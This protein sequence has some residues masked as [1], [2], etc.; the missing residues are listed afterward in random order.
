MSRSS[1]PADAQHGLLTQRIP[2]HSLEAERAVLGSLLLDGERTA[3]VAGGLTPSAFYKDGHRR[4]FAAMLHLVAV[5]SPVDLLTV[6]EVLKQRSELDD[7]GGPA[8]LAGLVEEAAIA[9]H[10]PAQICAIVREKSTKRELIRLGT[11]LVL[12]GYEE[13]EARV[14]LDAAR[15]SLRA[16]EAGPSSSTVLGVGLGAFLGQ[17]FSAPGRP[18]SRG[19]SCR[20]APGGLPARRSSARASMPYSRAS[21]S[22]RWACPCSA[23]TAS[24]ISDGCSSS[25]RKIRRDVSGPASG[26]SCADWTLTPTTLARGPSWTRF[27]VVVWEGVTLD[28]PQHLARLSATLDAF[29]AHVVYLDVLRKLTGKDLNKAQE[30]GALLGALDELRRRHG[31]V[32]RVLHHY[33]KSQG[34]RTGRGSQEIGGSFAL[35]AWGECSL[36]F[37]P[38]GR[39]QGAVRVEVQTKDGAPVPAFR[40]T[41]HAEGPADAPDLL[42][43]MAEDVTDD[44]SV[45][46]QLAQAVATLEKSEAVVGKPGVAVTALAA[47]LKKSDKSIRRGLKRLEASGR[48]VAIGQASKGVVLYGAASE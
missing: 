29:P 36:F 18:T 13:T 4:I 45:D 44:T 31:C 3:G 9:A 2:P 46:D 21:K 33:R 40:L 22:W 20:K 38:I 17:A 14:L 8:A 42:T 47:A 6:T 37:E 26:R 10:L 35:G 1:R 23:A 30:A 5:R 16:L 43:L 25:K 11:E 39:R 12:G 7:V 27:R 19:C 32:F 28:E 15:V 48:V 41:I 24:R 34:F